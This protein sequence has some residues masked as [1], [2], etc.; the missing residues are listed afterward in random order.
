M[1]ETNPL[2]NL[3]PQ[4]KLLLSRIVFKDKKRAEKY[5]TT[6][7]RGM[8]RAY[9]KACL[10]DDNYVTYYDYWTLP[11]FQELRPNIRLSEFKRYCASPASVPIKY[12][13]LLRDKG[14]EAF[15]AQYVEKN[16]YYRMVTGLPNYEDREYIYPSD[17]LRAEYG[18]PDVPVHELST[19]QQIQFMN[20]EEYS[21]L[22]VERPEKE[23][24]L[25]IGSNRVDLYAAR[26]A[27]DFSIIRYPTRDPEI[28]PVLLSMFANMYPKYR[29]YVM[30]ALYNEQMVDLYLNYREFLGMLIIAITLMQICNSSLEGINSHEFIDDTLIHTVFDMYGIPDSVLFNPDSRRDLSRGLM[31]LVRD[32]GT[33]DVYYDI[34]K[35]LGYTN[36]TISK[37]M[38]MRGQNFDE[39]GVALRTNTPYFMKANPLD[40]DPYATVKTSGTEEFKYDEV[41]GKDPEWWDTPEVR[42][43]IN[44]RKYTSADSKYIVIDGSVS[45]SDYLFE[46]LYFARMVLD[47]KNASNS[48]EFEI[49]DV[50]GGEKVSVYDCV[51]FL[52][53]AIS[54]MGEM[55][56]TL[57]RDSEELL[58]SAGFNFEYDRDG[59]QEFLLGCK[60]VDVKKL[61]RFLDNIEIKTVSDLRRV[62]LDVINPLHKWLE[63]QIAMT[64]T[65]EQFIEY[66]SIYRA[67]FSYDVTR[68]RLIDDYQKPMEILMERCSLSDDDMD[69]FRHF[70]PHDIDGRAITRS[71]LT[72]SIN[73]TRYSYPFLSDDHQ[74]DWYIDLDDRGIVYFY[75]ILNSN[76]CRELSN[77][78]GRVFMD[79]DGNDWV[80]NDAVMMQAFDAIDSLDDRQLASAALP[81][82]EDG[83]ASGTKLSDVIRNGSYKNILR[84]KLSLDLAGY[85]NPPDSYFECLYRENF[86]LYSILLDGDRFHTNREKWDSDLTAILT[87]MEK[88]VGMQLKYLEYSAVGKEMYFRPLIALI[89]HFKSIS[90]RIADTGLKLIFDSKFD[91]GGTS[92]MM[93]LFDSVQ[94]VVHFSTLSNSGYESNFGFYDATHSQ[95]TSII[96]NDY[97]QKLREMIGSGFLAQE[98]WKVMGSMHLS[99]ECILYVN[100]ETDGWKSGTPGDG[101]WAE[102]DDVLMKTRIGTRR[103]RSPEYDLDGW[104]DYVESLSPVE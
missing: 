49:P 55:D 51:L 70:Y 48:F 15:L 12:H 74:V 6:E 100:G 90:V 36:V 93:K 63:R 64:D 24:L 89:N 50:L 56:A 77:G 98:R 86:S 88:E 18:F 2:G 44:D 37:L 45:D 14:R 22:I 97:S 42:S 39:H 43:I 17:E 91:P 60:Y 27:N 85:S 3:F 101:R 62:F 30:S 69:L 83:F 102:D 59:L 35:V 104:V 1:K 4:I 5:E 8:G 58:A 66:E 32:K 95:R 11:M 84:E 41:T 75:D 78:A 34:I 81:I 53:C 99:D 33:S 68:N 26:S 21:K 28:N 20:S 9:L 80:L 82:T 7:T 40:V 96:I 57:S 87:A 94:F 23:Y 54:M 46:T 76:D 79:W 67:L 65:R 10:K 72:S 61:Y 47:N 52:I 16:D 31:K 25:Y 13:E 73:N 38:L 71:E 92:N 19:Y 103:V 29:E